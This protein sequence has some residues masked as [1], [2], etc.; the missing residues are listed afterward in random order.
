MKNKTTKLLISSAF[1]LS[2]FTANADVNDLMLKA[3]AGF[4]HTAEKVKTGSADT[5]TTHNFKDGYV[6][7][8]AINHF[9]DSVFGVEMSA[10]YGKTKF[11]NNAG[12]S[13]S[14]SFIP[15]TATFQ[16]R[17][18]TG[19]VTP[20]LGLGYSYHMMSKGAGSTKIKNGGGVVAQAGLDFMTSDTFGWNLDVKHTLKAKHTI[21]ETG[22]EIFKNKM[23]TTTAMVGLV[24]KY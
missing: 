17:H 2:A 9:F 8:L 11:K 19:S 22:G 24:F 21:T 5:A 16:V 12:N 3:R 14:I 13:K 1:A 18:N 6:G 20:Y 10:G 23:S 4:L 15:L 7:E